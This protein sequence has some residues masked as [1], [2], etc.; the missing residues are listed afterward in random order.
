MFIFCIFF[1]LRQSEHLHLAFPHCLR[2]LAIPCEI[3][4]SLAKALTSLAKA[5]TSLAKSLS[6][7]YITRR[8]SKN[9]RKFCVHVLPVFIL[10]YRLFQL[11]Y[12]MNFFKNL[13]I[14]I[15]FVYYFRLIYFPVL[16]PW[17]V[18]PR[19]LVQFWPLLM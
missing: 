13:Y 1:M 19:N 11:I 6:K 7:F 14:T 10:H 4:T 16:F 3:S 2:I 15:I 9:S 12:L 5:I 8:M 18:R 17:Y